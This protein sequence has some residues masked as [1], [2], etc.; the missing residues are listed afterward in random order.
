MFAICEK[1]V[2]N[3]N[4]RYSQR[5]KN[6]KTQALTRFVNAKKQKTP[7]AHKNGPKIFAFRINFKNLLKRA[8]FL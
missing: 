3:L 1:H 7:D 6:A 4:K 5:T 2:N 8:V